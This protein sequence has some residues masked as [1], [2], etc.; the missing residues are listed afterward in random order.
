M[1]SST[2]SVP[3]SKGRELAD[4]AQR[5]AEMARYI[6]SPPRLVVVLS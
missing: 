2:G 4:Q 6:H 1:P 5:R 3:T